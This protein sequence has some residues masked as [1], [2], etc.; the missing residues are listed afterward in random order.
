MPKKKIRKGPF[1]WIKWVLIGAVILGLVFIFAAKPVFNI[2][3]MEKIRSNRTQSGSEAILTKVQD[4]FMFQ[5]VEYVYKTVFPYDFV[6]PDYP[7][8][9]LLDK[10]A[11]GEPLS[12]EEQEHL[13][14][15]RFCEEIGIKLQSNKYEFVV[16]TAIVRG[17]FNLEG[18]I[19]ASSDNRYN[20]EKYIQIDRETNTLYLRLPPP[21]ITNFEIEDLDRSRYP[22]PELAISPD[23]W[24]RLTQFTA[25]EIE[26]QVLEDGILELAKQRGKVFIEKLLLDSGLETIVFLEP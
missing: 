3:I 10:E 24:K 8:R 5:T 7:W 25:N 11:L 15:F 6:S 21:V 13:R 22:Y 26:R 14:I 17:G 16:V 4:L 12:E 2:N 9:T 19:Y 1:R 20:V 18:T 23:N